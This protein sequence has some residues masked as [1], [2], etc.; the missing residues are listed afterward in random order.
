MSIILDIKTK[1]QVLDIMLRVFN[2]RRSETLFSTL[3]NIRRLY[4][5][6][7]EI[8]SLSPIDTKFCKLEKYQGVYDWENNKIRLNIDLIKDKDYLIEIAFHEWLHHYQYS[9]DS[10]L[11]YIPKDIWDNCWHD[12]W[13]LEN[14]DAF[15]NLLSI[16]RAW[17]PV[18][19]REPLVEV[20]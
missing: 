15:L 8:Y 13:F 1:E 16:K 5:L 19:M 20:S 12:D 9:K 6:L 7:N 2:I 17:V 14:L 11:I 10:S 3:S 4:D 18:Y